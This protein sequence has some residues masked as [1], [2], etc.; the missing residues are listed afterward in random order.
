M[1]QTR[2]MSALEITTNYTLGVGISWLISFYIM[3]YWGFEQTAQAAT[4]ITAIYT[5]TS[6]MRSYAIR[7]AFNWIGQR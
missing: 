5:V 1:S 4:A 3:P 2:R 6:I 7:R